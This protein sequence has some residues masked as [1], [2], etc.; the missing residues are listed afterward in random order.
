[1][2]DAERLVYTLLTAIAPD[3]VRVAPETDSEVL[4][5]LPLW[6]YHL[7]GDGQVANGP[8]LYTFSLDIN[9]FAEGLDATRAQARL[10]HDGV[11]RW[12][13]PA[14]AIVPDVG[15]VADVADNSIFSLQ[16]TPVITGRQVSQYAG[17]F[18]LALRN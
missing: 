6:Q 9:V 4:G 5:D 3:G 11:H 15:W 10:C 1:M 14:A 7:L 17:S 13:N 18:D 2:I 12:E 16:G 8:G